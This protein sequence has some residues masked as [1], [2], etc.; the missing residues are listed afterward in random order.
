[1]QWGQ[2]KTL[3]ILC[4]LLLDIYLLVLFLEKEQEAD[5]PFLNNPDLSIEETLEQEKIG[6]P[7]ELPEE[8]PD[9]AF[10]QANQ[11]HFTDE[12]LDRI[13][14]LENQKV[15]N[16]N[17]NM[18][19]SIF[20]EP[21]TLPEKS[22]EEAIEQL[23]KSNILFPEEFSFEYWD[24]DTNILVFFQRKNERAIYFNQNALLL[25][26]LNDDNEFVAYTQSMLGEPESNNDKKSLISPI[27]A[28]D[29]LYEENQLFSGQAVTD[30]DIGYYTMFPLDNGTQVF[31][32]TW[33]LT[34][35]EERDL[36]VNAT[37]RLVYPNNE[38]FIEEAI[39]RNLERVRLIKDQPDLKEE[40]VN[41]LLEKY[42]VINRS[43]EE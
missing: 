37:E 8:L 18:I 1:M 35:D 34:V 11:K 26:Y 23:V 36:F 27:L 41:I 12:E 22:S 32:P 14:S 43:E 2:I 10:I 16:V 33:K 9:E 25:V 31:V 7:D 30:M 42:E 3:F 19:V 13:T 5:R 38:G 15:T 28:I 4:F 40:M 39:N 6:I 29:T 24:T 17:K 20:E 21:I